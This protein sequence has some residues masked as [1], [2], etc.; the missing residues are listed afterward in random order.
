ME[1]TV[2]LHTVNGDVRSAFPPG[3]EDQAIDT[4]T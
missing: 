2:I 4:I 1:I 3:Y